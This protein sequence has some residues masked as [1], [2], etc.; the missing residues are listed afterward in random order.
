MSFPFPGSTLRWRHRIML[1]IG[2]SGLVGLVGAQYLSACGNAAVAVP[3][4]K[5]DRAPTLDCWTRAEMEL[6]AADGCIGNSNV[7]M[8]RATPAETL[9]KANFLPNGC[10]AKEHACDGCCNPAAQEGEPQ[11]D[12]SCCYY[13]CDNVCCGRPL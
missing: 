3:T 6:R 11:G 5:N 1:T 12:G 8:T 2:S 10:L 7:A 4:C 13:H 9:I